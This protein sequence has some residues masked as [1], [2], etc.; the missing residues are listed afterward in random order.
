MAGEHTVS[1]MD[2]TTKSEF[3][4]EGRRGEGPGPSG[5]A[6]PPRPAAT[7]VLIR[8]SGA[9]TEVLLTVR[10]R[11]LRFMGGAAVFPGGAVDSGDLDP[12]WEGAS[13]RS[14][15]DAARALGVANEAAAL[16]AFVC[17]IREAFEEVGWIAGAG[18]L[19]RID[20]SDSGDADRFRSACGAAG[21]VL[22]TDRLVP[23]GRWVTPLGSLRRFDTHFFVTVVDPSWEPRP[24]SDEVEDCLWATPSKALAELAA[25]RLLMAPPTIEMLQ[26]LARHTD[27]ASML[28]ALETK[29]VRA[30]GVIST[31]LSAMVHV[32]VAPN[33][34][35]LTGP[36]TNTYI[37]GAGPTCVIDPAVDDPD[38]IEAVLRAAGPIDAVLVTHRHPD[39]V[40]GIEAL[41]A[42]TGAVV[43]AFGSAP[44]GGVEV[45][46]LRDGEVVE[47]GGVRLQAIH[48]PG[49]A[50]DHHCFHSE[51]TAALFSGDNILGEG[52]AVIAPPDGDMRAY[53]ASLTSLNRLHIE[54]IFP[55]HFR[56]LDGGNAV[57]DAYLEHR[58]S[59][60]RAILAALTGGPADVRTLVARVYTDVA[61]ELHGLAAYSVQAYLEMAKADGVVDRSGQMWRSTG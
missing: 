8:E 14:R 22:A 25:G 34:G 17:A 3:F 27:A 40:G 61:P 31:M 49:H 43:R 23:A 42:E 48:S 54:R 18:P 5:D 37:V 32:V 50:P 45:V 28:G 13:A 10:P 21:V 58:D 33:P 4:E 7:V 41:V 46:P 59:R 51:A 52:T 24:A 36:G 55:G 12:E 38:Y 9:E 19:E 35:L 30:G 47:V 16:G 11:H 39:H 60:H 29:G 44:A 53:L 2:L 56:A 20:R 1:C 26:K 57:I 15:R 6:A